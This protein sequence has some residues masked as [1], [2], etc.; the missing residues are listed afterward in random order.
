MENQSA[1]QGEPSHS[2]SGALPASSKTASL[3]GGDSTAQTEPSMIDTGGQRQAEVMSAASSKTVSIVELARANDTD[4]LAK[5]IRSAD[6]SKVKRHA[7]TKEN[8]LRLLGNIEPEQLKLGKI[9]F[10]PNRSLVFVR[11]D[12]PVRLDL[13]YYIDD[14]SSYQLRLQAIHP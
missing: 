1:K 8:V 5:A 6:E 12:E 9:H 11:I 7:A 3:T 14:S 4:Q 2:K 13:E 10:D